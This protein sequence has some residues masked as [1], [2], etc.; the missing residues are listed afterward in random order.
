[1]KS[2]KFLKNMEKPVPKIFLFSFIIL[3][4]SCS[5][6]QSYD[7]KEITK[8]IEKTAQKEF[9]I[10][11]IAND[12]GQTLWIYAPFKDLIDETN[13]INP[14]RQKDLRN[15]F[16]TLR[17]TILNIN[18]PPRFFVFVASNI[19]NIGVDFY[20]VGFI[21]DLIHYEFSQ[22]SRTE[23]DDRTV[24]IPF[25]NEQALEDEVGGHLIPLYDFTMADFITYLTLQKIRKTFNDE[26]IKESAK[27]K[28]LDGKYADKTLSIKV[29]IE[30]AG[31]GKDMPNPFD[32]AK[33]DLIKFL[34]IYKEFLP[35]I[36][37][38]T[39]KA[40]DKSKSYSLK[41]LLEK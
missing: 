6:P 15:I 17:R 25:E 4:L 8:I 13:S 18:K 24:Q 7:R 32:E 26:E 1:M 19:K 33:N 38:I 30:F 41:S 3:V 12:I 28:Q 34:N 21:P 36:Q 16:L 35:E 10:K 39:I 5:L 14:Q 40:N 9:N 11:V 2:L 29:N 27:I 23:Y 20:Q 22:I 37:L 31:K